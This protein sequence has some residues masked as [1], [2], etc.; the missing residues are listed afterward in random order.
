MEGMMSTNFSLSKPM[1]T[2][3]AK[4]GI[5]KIGQPVT[6]NEGDIRVIKIQIGDYM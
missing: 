2:D 3:M 4:S 6:R 1:S 5:K